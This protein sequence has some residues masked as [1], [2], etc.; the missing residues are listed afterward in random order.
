MSELNKIKSKIILNDIKSS[1]LRKRIF[2]FLCE[3]Q[4]LEIVK[5]NKELQNFLFID[6]KDYIEYYQKDILKEF[7]FDKTGKGIEKYF[8]F[9]KKYEGTYLNGKKNGKI[10]LYDFLEHLLFEGEYLKGKKKWNM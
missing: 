1:Y 6:I 5:Y 2:F 7:T 9:K 4:K 8:Q 3:K 10:K